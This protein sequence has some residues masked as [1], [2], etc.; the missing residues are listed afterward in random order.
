[1]KL[2]T[3]IFSFN[4]LHIDTLCVNEQIVILLLILLS[5]ERL[6]FDDFQGQRQRE[7]FESSSV[8][9]FSPSYYVKYRNIF[10]SLISLN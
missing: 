4:L 5:T 10:Y 9:E 8:L 7:L 1:M 2:N 3:L 6:R